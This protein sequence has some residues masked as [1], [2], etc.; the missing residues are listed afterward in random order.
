MSLCPH[1]SHGSSKALSLS[2]AAGLCWFSLCGLVHAALRARGPLCPAVLPRERM[3]LEVG[4]KLFI[5]WYSCQ[6]LFLCLLVPFKYTFKSILLFVWK[7]WFRKESKIIKILIPSAFSA[8]WCQ[9][10][11]ALGVSRDALWLTKCLWWGRSSP[12]ISSHACSWPLLPST[13]ESWRGG[14]TCHFCVHS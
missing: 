10:R 4:I 14:C 11:S 7:S 2:E 1:C 5:Q 8:K 13:Q 6:L 3:A 12:V 9:G